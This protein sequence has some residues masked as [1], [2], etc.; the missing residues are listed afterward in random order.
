[1]EGKA[2]GFSQKHQ[3][4]QAFNTNHVKPSRANSLPVSNIWWVDGRKVI[5]FFPIFLHS[6]P[7]SSSSYFKLANA[8]MNM[9]L[10]SVLSLQAMIDSFSH[11]LNLCTA[12]YTAWDSCIVWHQRRG[13]GGGPTRE[14]AKRKQEK[15][16]KAARSMWKRH[17][18][19]GSVKRCA[20]SGD[21]WWEEML[22][23]SCWFGLVGSE[24]PHGPCCLCKAGWQRASWKWPLPQTWCIPIRVTT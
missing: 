16:P 14:K 21:E 4:Y 5:Q 10:H 2:C 23:W 12:F 24:Q 18:R 13:L 15:E 7:L 9:K 22:P 3:D 20:A 1:M 6:T 17:M 8:P 11:I 19:Y